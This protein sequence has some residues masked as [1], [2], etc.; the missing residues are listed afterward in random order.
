MAISIKSRPVTAAQTTLAWPLGQPRVGI[1]LVTLVLALGLLFRVSHLERKA[2]WGD[3]VYSSLRVL[4][5]KTTEVAKG[6]ATGAPIAVSA[7]QQYQR[8]A[9]GKSM[10]DTVNV[11]IQ[12]DA[13]LTPLYFVLGRI[14][15]AGVGSSVV[16]MRS[17]SVLFS[18]LTLPAGYWLS[19]EL[20]NSVPIARLTVV[21]N[22]VSPLYLV[23]A[24]EARMYSLW[25]LTT[26]VAMASLLHALRHSTWKSW[27]IFSLALTLQLYAHLFSLVMLLAYGAYVLGLRMVNPAASLRRFS[28]A[29]G[30]AL[31]AFFPW[32]WVFAHRSVQSKEELTE[33]VSLINTVKHW[34]GIFSQL[35]VDFNTSSKILSPALALSLIASVLG[36]GVVIYGIYALYRETSQRTWLFI[37]VILVTAP[38]GPLYAYH[39]WMISARYLMPGYV[40]LQLIAAYVLGSRAFGHPHQHP[41]SRD[42]D[43]QLSRP[44]QQAWGGM[45]AVIVLSGVLSCGQMAMSETWWNKQYSNCNTQSAQLINQSSHPLVISDI[46]GGPLFDHP[47]SNVL[48]L[49]TL[50]QPHVQLQIFTPQNYSAIA[51][52]FADRFV[53]TPSAALR[54][55]LQKV[56]GDR[57]QSLYLGSE[58]YRGSNICLWQITQSQPTHAAITGQRSTGP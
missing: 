25:L 42:L 31:V 35:F 8:L 38:L 37:V 55:H 50:L 33:P 5:F 45:L 41:C 56:Y 52:A 10:G 51:D 19:R 28:W 4:G 29:A 7:V 44:Q 40:G 49:S 16:A 30:T 54:A 26:T 3:E 24:Q 9:P 13:H 21:L 57:F 2:Y 22:L 43:R 58:H 32:L 39:S 48:S 17:L 14:W 20:F 6:I 15:V 27:G 53:I 18:L 11:L 36:L 12:E 34:A 23:Y 1:F 46:G 47:L